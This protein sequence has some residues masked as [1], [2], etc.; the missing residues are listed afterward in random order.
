M[1]NLSLLDNGKS[2]LENN[3]AD[4]SDLILESTS[5]PNAFIDFEFQSQGCLQLGFPSLADDVF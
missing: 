4:L 2:A 1:V 5:N 3:I